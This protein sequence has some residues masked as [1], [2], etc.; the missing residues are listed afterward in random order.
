RPPGKMGTGGFSISFR[1]DENLFGVLD[2]DTTTDW[3]GE[4]LSSNFTSIFSQ[5]SG[6]SLFN[7]TDYNQ[8]IRLLKEGYIYGFL[9]IPDKFEYNLTQRLTA[10]LAIVDDAT[11]AETAA[12]LTAALEITIAIFKVV[13]GM[14]RDEI[15]PL[16]YGEFAQE[17]S[18]L[19]KA[20]PLIF[21]ILIFGSGILLASQCIVGDEPLRRTLLT[22]AAKLEVILAKTIAYS[23]IHA[24]QVQLLMFIAMIFFRLPVFGGFHVSFILLFMVAFCGIMIGMFISVISKTRLQANQMF[25]LVFILFLLSLIFVTEPAINAWMPMYNGVDGFTSYAF[26]GFD[27]SMQPWPIISLSI[28]S[29]IF[30]TLTI[31]CFH[32]KKTVE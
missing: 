11:D 12:T 28:M 4:D 16:V 10:E 17:N 29:G 18:P 23:S 13:H 5:Y 9:V 6:Y 7:L 30:L 1:A 2:L 21:A 24:V 15:F 26:K 20:G 31:V 22:P 25:L 14:I 3:P 19:F 27:F 32:F 8:G